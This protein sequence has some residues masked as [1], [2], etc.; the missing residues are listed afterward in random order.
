MGVLFDYFAA[1]DDAAAATAIDNGPDG[2]FDTLSTKVDCVVLLGELEHLLGGRSFDDQLDDPRADGLV[3][4]R[5]EGDVQVLTISRVTQDVL[6]SASD[7]DLPAV[8][9]EWAQA[10]EFGGDAEPA[11]LETLAR[12]LCALARRANDGGLGMYCW[13]CP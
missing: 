4:D 9:R 3:S 5:D 7:A 10:E 13:V 12:D 6:A 8:A 2:L 11:E 1:P